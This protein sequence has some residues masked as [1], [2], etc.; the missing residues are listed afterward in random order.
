MPIILGFGKW[1]QEDQELIIIL[2]YIVSSRPAWASWDPVSKK[3][4]KYLILL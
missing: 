4:K 3:G 1:K 2:G